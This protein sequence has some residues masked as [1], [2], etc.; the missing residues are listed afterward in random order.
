[1]EPLE[2]PP[3]PTSP[4]RG[5]N[6]P[7]PFESLTGRETG[8]PGDPDFFDLPSPFPTA[9]TVPENPSNRPAAGTRDDRNNINLRAER[10]K[11]LGEVASVFSNHPEAQQAIV[12]QTENSLAGLPDE[13]KNRVAKD[14]H[15][16]MLFDVRGSDPDPK[17]DAST[18]F[19]ARILRQLEQGNVPIN[20][21]SSALQDRLQRVRR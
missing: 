13:I 20:T 17:T 10:E 21:L 8:L 18:S 5:S 16:D 4:Q 7:P 19:D 14:W 11:L 1:L 2:A 12:N 3:F 9:P 15:N 6:E